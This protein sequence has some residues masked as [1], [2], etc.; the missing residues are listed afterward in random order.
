[1]TDRLPDRRTNAFRDDLAAASLRDIVEAPRYAEGTVARV[2]VG[3]APLR[4]RPDAASPLDTEAVFGEHVTV[5]DR[6]GGWAWVQLRRDG[7]VGYTPETALADD[8]LQPTHRVQ[9]LATFVYP[10]PDIKAPPVMSLPMGAQVALSTSG[11]R[12]A[13]LVTGG[14]VILRH[15]AEIGRHAPDFVDVAERFIGTPYLWGGRT[16]LGL[17]CSGLLQVALEASGRQCP[18]DSDMQEASLGTSVLVPEHLDGLERGDLVF[19]PGHVGIMVDS[20]M[21]LHANA[22]HMVVAVE[23]LTAAAERIARTGARIAAI[24]RLAGAAADASA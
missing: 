23:P 5:L 4:Q 3:Q 13:E 17:D 16:R 1:M 18:R 12:F 8:V 22:H 6:S 19:W 21:L 11:E 9:A 2:A 15:L 14:H 20:V 10:S 24:K 7:Y